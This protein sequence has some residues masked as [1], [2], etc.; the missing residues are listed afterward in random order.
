MS[1]YLLS[2]NL[3]IACSPNCLACSASACTQCS[4]G[5]TVISGSCISCMNLTQGG[6]IGCTSCQTIGSSIKCMNCSSG[7]YLAPTNTCKACS[8]QFNN[9]ILC[10]SLSAIQ[11][12]NDY[13]P[14]LS[15]RY[16]LFNGICIQNKNK[17][18]T[19][20]NAQGQCSSCYF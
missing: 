19:I 6:S 20:I 4:V 16:Y 13:D 7:Y 10:T 5:Y 9:S 3:C 2:S 18:K 12:A 17:C 11:C 1:G 14:I 15:N 8:S